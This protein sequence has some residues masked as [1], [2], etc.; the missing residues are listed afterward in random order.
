M[1]TV[2]F[3]WLF[4]VPSR[5][6]FWS[7]LVLL[8]ASSFWTSRR[9]L[10]REIKLTTVEQTILRQKRNWPNANRNVCPL[11]YCSIVWRKQIWGFSANE[12]TV[13]SRGGSMSFS[14]G[15]DFQINFDLSFVDQIDFPGSPKALKWHY[16]GPNFLHRR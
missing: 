10:R 9:R 1:D 3:V 4:P 16:F 13:K 2:V 15:A 6:T 12:T 7:W 11:K 5:G 8:P 14:R